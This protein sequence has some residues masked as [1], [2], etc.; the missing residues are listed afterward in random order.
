MSVQFVK[1]FSICSVAASLALVAA[2]A[3]A[4]PPEG[5][6][7]V[8][9][10]NFQLSPRYSQ[11]LLGPISWMA[12]SQEIRTYLGLAD[13][14]DAERFINEFWGQRSNSDS[15]WPTDQPRLVFEQRA[16]EADT[17][18]SEGT[19]YGRWTDRGTIYILYGEPEKSYYEVPERPRSPR[20]PDP[21][22]VWSYAK[23]AAKGLDGEQPKR[24]YF[25]VKR[26]E[27]TVFKFG[28]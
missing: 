15:P 28:R 2:V 22:E 13:D 4:G 18:F 21:V 1:S 17:R 16:T 11:W 8:D 25:F 5:M 3:Q 14:A 23:S 10:T 12:S 24:K 26:G 6:D 20:P 9:L 19:R 7:T 27:S